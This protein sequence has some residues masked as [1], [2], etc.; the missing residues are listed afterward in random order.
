MRLSVMAAPGS[1][2]GTDFGFERRPVPERQL[3]I[4]QPASRRDKARAKSKL[5]EA[6][7]DLTR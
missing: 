4:D 7:E 2:L 3:A 6:N 1:A 5:A